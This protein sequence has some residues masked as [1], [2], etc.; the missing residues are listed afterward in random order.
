M[1]YLFKTVT[2][3]VALLFLSV[4]YVSSANDVF[5]ADNNTVRDGFVAAY[6]LNVRFEP[7]TNSKILYVLKEGAKIKI[8]GDVGTIG[9]WVQ[10]QFE[11]QKGYVRNRSHYIKVIKT[12]ESGTD[13]VKTSDKEIV[14]EKRDK[15]PDKVPDTTPAEKSVKKPAEKPAEK[16]VEKPV[17]KPAGKDTEKTDKCTLDQLFS[18]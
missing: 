6:R 14:A 18:N 10:I 15:V 3:I 8:Y 9:A 16:S 11:N 12:V 1:L 17:G 5:S 4:V 2:K 13:S 7:S